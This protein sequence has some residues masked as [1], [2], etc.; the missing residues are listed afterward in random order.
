[1][2]LLL[3]SDGVCVLR[4]KEPNSSSWIAQPAQE[5]T[6]IASEL[7]GKYMSAGGSQL[8][9]LKLLRTEMKQEIDSLARDLNEIQQTLLT[10]CNL[11]LGRRPASGAGQHDEASDPIRQQRRRRL[12]E[13]LTRKDD[14]KGMSDGSSS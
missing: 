2:R 8:A 3:S 10:N 14:S 1:M 4:R 6:K 11:E 12:E 7:I 13:L 5:P 9:A